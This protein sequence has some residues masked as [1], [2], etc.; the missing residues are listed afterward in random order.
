MPK[1]LLRIIYGGSFES[2]VLTSTLS[3]I[4][5]ICKFHAKTT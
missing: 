1:P 2:I 3:L 4:C 5:G